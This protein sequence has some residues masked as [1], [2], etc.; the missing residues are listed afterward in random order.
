MGNLAEVSSTTGIHSWQKPGTAAAPLTDDQSSRFH[1]LQALL[2]LAPSRLTLSKVASRPL[3]AVE[4]RIN[5]LCTVNPYRPIQSTTAITSC[6]LVCAASH[7]GF[8]F[9]CYD[10]YRPL[11]FVNGPIE[12]SIGDRQLIAAVSD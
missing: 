1:K 6:M 11:V 2:V 8:V 12:S 3:Y 7:W 10:C 5:P 9:S 4:S